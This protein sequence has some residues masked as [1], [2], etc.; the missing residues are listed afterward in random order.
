MSDSTTTTATNIN[1]DILEK[2]PLSVWRC[3][4]AFNVKPVNKN[5]FGIFYTGDTY[6][7][8]K[9]LTK[10]GST[11]PTGYNIHY[12]L[13]KEASDDEKATAASR[14]TDFEEHL[15]GEKFVIKEVQGQE[16]EKFRSYFMPSIT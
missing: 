3:Q 7:V 1:Y 2:E 8:V 10:L 16:S 9:Q 5:D 4:G 6:I 12:W 14:V 11:T 15:K 13:G